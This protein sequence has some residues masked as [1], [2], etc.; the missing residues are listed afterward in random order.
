M[1]E[2]TSFQ[3]QLTVKRVALRRQPAAWS[4]GRSQAANDRQDGVGQPGWASS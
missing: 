3:E 4:W 1:K 2:S